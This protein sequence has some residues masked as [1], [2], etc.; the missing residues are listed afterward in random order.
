MIAAG[1]DPLFAKLVEALGKPALA[2]DERFA[3]NDARTR[4]HGS[5]KAE[6]ENLLAARPSTQW[7]AILDKVG[8]PCGPINTVA[9]ALADPQIVA[10]NM[11]VSTDDPVAGNLRMAGNPI[12]LSGFPD[13][14]TRGPTPELDGDRAAILKELGLNT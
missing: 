10:R 8:V 5:L 11:V 2:K 3:T 14:A 6:L 4:N 1:N 13:P 9:D 7:L 12:K